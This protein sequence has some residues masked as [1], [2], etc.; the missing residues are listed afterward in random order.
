MELTH[1]ENG[2]GNRNT[3]WRAI[4]AEGVF[5]VVSAGDPDD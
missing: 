2:T 3:L 1:P 5:R 4:H